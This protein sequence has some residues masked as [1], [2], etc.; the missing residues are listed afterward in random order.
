MHYERNPPHE[1]FLD[2]LP[3]VYEFEYNSK[4]HNVTFDRNRRL[5]GSW[6]SG[7]WHYLNATDI[8]VAIL[9]HDHYCLQ[10]WKLNYLLQ[11]EGQSP[12]EISLRRGPR[13]PLD[14][15]SWGVTLKLHHEKACAALNFPQ[16]SLH[17]RLPQPPSKP[18]I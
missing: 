16:H 9:L 1:F 15:F 5:L 4:V 3:A 11:I 6:S 14:N 2:P 12:L 8:A 10:R 18:S 7:T 17:L 13:P